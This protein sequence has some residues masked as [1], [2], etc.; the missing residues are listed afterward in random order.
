MQATAYARRVEHQPTPR[1][2]EYEAFA[3][4]TAA[5]G[6]AKSGPFAALATALHENRRLWDMLAADIAG[7]ANE[8]PVELRARIF[9]LA[10]FTRLQ[11]GRI[12]AGEAEPDILVEIN[13]AIMRGLRAGPEAS[14]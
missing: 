12:L 6:T 5:L 1:A 11:T 9:Y 2:V 8:L 4:V 7:D 10:E 13:T 14:R 3:R